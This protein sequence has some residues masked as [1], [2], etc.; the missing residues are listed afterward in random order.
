MDTKHVRSVFVR[1]I[2]I[3]V[4]LAVAF[5]TTASASAAG[6]RPFVGVWRAIDNLD[7]SLIR[8]TIMGSSG[9]P[10]LITW[11]EPYLSFCEGRAGLA[12][13]IGYLDTD[14]PYMLEANMRLKC[15]RSGDTIEWHQ[16][17]QYRPAYDVLASSGDYGVETIWTRLGQPLVS[18][19]DLRVNYGDDW[20]ESFYQSDHTVWITVTEGDGITVKATA[21]LVTEPKDFWDGETGFQTQPSDWIPAPPDIQ[22][23]DW[24]IAEVDNGQTARVQ[25]GDVSGEIDLGADSILGTINATWFSEEVE[26]ECHSWGAPLPEEILKYDMTLPN[27]EETYA[28]SWAG[29][30][31]I[32]PGQN[33]GVGYFGPDGHW[34]ANTFFIPMP[35]FVAYL[36][37][38]IEGYDW[39]LGHE[40]TVNINGGEYS[41]SAYSEQRPDFPEGETRVLFELWRDDF[42]MEAG[43][44]L[45]MTDE[46]AGITKDVTVTNLAVTDINL[47]AHTVSG[48]YDPAYELWVWLYGQDGQVPATEGN[49][50][51]ATFTEL[52]PRT[53]GGATQRD[54]DGDGTSLDFQIP[55]PNLYALPDENKIFAQ[56][57][58]V[59]SQLDLK[60][61]DSGGSEIYSDSQMVETPSVVPWTLVVFDL[62]AAGFDLMPGQQIVLNQRGYVRELLVSSL[63]IT[64]F[65]FV[66]QQVIGTGDAGALIFIRINGED[67]W[68]EVD[69]EGNWATSHPQLAPRVWGEAIQPDGVDGDETRDGFQA[70]N[71]GLYALTDENKI[72]AQEWMVGGQLDLQIYDS[73]GSEIYAD[74]QIVGPPSEVPWTLVVFD[75]G[76]AAFDLL[77]EQRIVLNQGGYEREMIVSSLRII[78][79]EYVT[80][81]ITGIGDAGAHIFI[82]INGEDIWGEVDS[83]GNWAISHPQLAPGVWGE[84]IQP[85]GVDG[86]ETRD[87]FQ[88]P[89]E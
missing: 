25:I 13:G 61:Y 48:I 12:T 60:V 28:C 17:W 72:Y 78:G 51:V 58:I 5:S 89:Y 32:Q 50:W 23:M 4:I 19:L 10:F 9:G 80:Q 70:P 20:V 65:D 31:D 79:F 46:A 69:S 42:F 57:W 74:S 44:H 33:V 37:G 14:D 16:V 15:L 59:G 41:T 88:A 30:W 68:G 2:Y 35:T 87:G 49:T 85:D 18:R 11:T 38:A 29:E 62:D 63:T 8:V 40:I 34:V 3:T 84:A 45:V 55:N 56:E 39:P 7:G 54:T 82:R 53:W 73:G 22:P 71:P 52:L 26:V 43:D 21:Q 67:V 24:V 81:Q 36:P 47:G 75:L 76:T 77:P 66:N 64:G 86:D 1:A 27:G 6:T 83:E